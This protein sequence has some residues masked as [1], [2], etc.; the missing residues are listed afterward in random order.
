MTQ[1]A[2]YLNVDNCIGCKVCGMACMEKNDLLSGMRFRR[3]LLNST[4]SWE[5]DASGLYVANGVFAYSLSVAC[6]HCAR[7]ACVEQ[8]PTGAMVKDSDTGIVSSDPETCIGCGTCGEA[9]PY[10]VPFVDPER[11]IA[12]KCDFCQ[13][14]LAV[15]EVPPC[16][17]ACSMNA[18]EYGDIEE[19]REKHSDA[20]SSIDP[21]PSPDLTGPSL[22][23]VPPA[24]YADGLDITNFNLPEELEACRR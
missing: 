12:R 10:G 23:L 22:L 4:G 19:L 6:N 11:N 14:Y 24:K 21:L 2:F 1:Y 13:E 5:K 15:G 20:V 18:L 7:P 3:I 17:G 16:V 9:C 8:C